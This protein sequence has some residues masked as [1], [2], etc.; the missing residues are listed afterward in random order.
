[1]SIEAKLAV[2]GTGSIGQAI[3]V[4]LAATA[5]YEAS[6]II[7]T[8]R[9][10]DLLEDLGDQGFQVQSDNND[11]VRR[12]DLLVVAV[13]PQELDQL[14]RE[15]AESL[16]PRRHRLIS[17]VSDVSIAQIAKQVGA[18]LPMVRAMPN[19]AIAFGQSM[20]CLAAREHDEDAL[21]EATRLFNTVGRTQVIPE[22]QI[23][24]ATAIC[25]CGTAFFLRLIRAAMQGGIQIGFHPH[26]ALR[27]AAQ[28]ALGASTVILDTNSHPESE[29]DRVTTPRGCTIVGLNEMEDRGISS[30]MIRGIVASAEKA[31]SLY[32]D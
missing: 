5:G 12:A 14:L 9:Q 2:L 10:A 18:D 24:A 6:E 16:E 30:A 17:V 4:G 29:L 21:A 3:G 15:I 11:A 27:M 8:R 32:A 28:T 20:T 26:E 31:E 13:P 1:M 22:S 7:L 25:A 23:V 19:T